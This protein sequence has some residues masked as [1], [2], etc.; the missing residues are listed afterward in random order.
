MKKQGYHQCRLVRKLSGT[1]TV[2]QLRYIPEQFA[3]LNKPLK[4]KLEDGTWQDGWI[5]RSVG[6]YTENPPD[7]RKAIRG[8][9]DHTGD[10]LPK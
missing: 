1:S 9:R 10:S 2:E 8:H 4:L 3:A 5:V 6:S 7:W